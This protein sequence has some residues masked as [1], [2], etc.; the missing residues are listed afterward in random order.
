MQLLC[1][2]RLAKLFLK[3]LRGTVV[4]KL[5][6]KAVPQPLVWSCLA[7]AAFRNY[8]ANVCMA[9][10]CKDCFFFEAVS[11]AFSWNCRAKCILQS[12]F[13]KFHM[14]LL[15]TKTVRQRSWAQSE[16]CWAQSNQSVRDAACS[17]RAQVAL[18]SYFLS[19]CMEL[20]CKSCLLK[21]FL[22]LLFG[23]VVKKLA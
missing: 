11:R 21:I 20:L 9:S 10:P 18:R 13:S 5:R 8:F 17:S 15:R 19:L 22:Q 2:S 6:C 23:T 1:K 7:K 14:D 12:C 4:Q 16:L 3:V